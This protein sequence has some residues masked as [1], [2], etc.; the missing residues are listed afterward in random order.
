MSRTE[1]CLMKPKTPVTVLISRTVTLKMA[2]FTVL[3]SRTLLL[4]QVGVE[5]VHLG[6]S[7]NANLRLAC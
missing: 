5:T 1:P 6:K 7:K 3:L 2:I 4:Y